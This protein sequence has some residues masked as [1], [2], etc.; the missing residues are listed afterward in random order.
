[1][2]DLTAERPKPM[3]PVQ[4]RPLL[5]HIVESAEEA[6]IEEILLVVGYKAEL[7]REYFETHRPARARLSYVV[8]EKP[9]GTGSATLLGKEFAGGERVLLTFGDILARASTYRAIFDLAEA[10]T[11]CLPSR[12]WTTPTEAPLCMSKATASPASS[13][14][15]QREPRRH[16]SSMP[17]SIASARRCLTSW[18][19]I[20]CQR[21][22]SMN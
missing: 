20:L 4:G 2:K 11:A 10:R 21:V 12:K 22:A 17:V 19:A 3:L 1:M 15:H 16:G 7:V 9:D 8:Q 18:S 6:G 14:S 5:A 13:R